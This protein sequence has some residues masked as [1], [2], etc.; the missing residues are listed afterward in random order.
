M[1]GTSLVV[2]RLELLI[3]TAGGTDSQ[4][5]PMGSVG[6]KKKKEKKSN[7]RSPAW[8]TSFSC[9][10]LDQ[11]WSTEWRFPRSE[12]S[13]TSVSGPLPFHTWIRK[14][15]YLSTKILRVFWIN[16]PTPQTSQG[17]GTPLQYSCLENP[18]DRGAWKAA[19]HGVAEGWTQLKR[20]SSS[21]SSRWPRE[22]NL[23]IDETVKCERVWRQSSFSPIP[24]HQVNCWIVVCSIDEMATVFPSVGVTRPESQKLWDYACGDVWFWGQRSCLAPV[25]AVGSQMPMAVRG[26]SGTSLVHYG[27]NNGLGPYLGKYTFFFTHYPFC[28]TRP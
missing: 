12:V 23:L 10:S 3:S 5:P 14:L 7:G 17:N 22:L 26:C 15:Q 27:R 1:G 18:M 4:I 2:Q 9:P 16:I 8:P 21:S 11:V 20:L 19:V 6:Q 13:I 24:S 28:F 25:G